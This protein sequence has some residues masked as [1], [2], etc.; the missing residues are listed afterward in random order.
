MVMIDSVH[1]GQ[2]CIGMRTVCCIQSQSHMDVGYGALAWSLV[3]PDGCRPVGQN[4]F[5][6]VEILCR[7]WCSG[8][9]SCLTW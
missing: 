5:M 6:P 2:G 1:A 7:L 4:T 9:Q 3:W 8:M